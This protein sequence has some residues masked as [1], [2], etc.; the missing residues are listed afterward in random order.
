VLRSNWNGSR[1]GRE[2]YQVIRI[3]VPIRRADDMR[4][5]EQMFQRDALELANLM[6]RIQCETGRTPFYG[7]VSLTGPCYSQYH[8]G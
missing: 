5:D 8:G 1:Q 6:A 4:H 2:S 7:A 3:G